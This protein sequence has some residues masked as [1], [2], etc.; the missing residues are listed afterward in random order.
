MQQ[1]IIMKKTIYEVEKTCPFLE[2]GRKLNLN[3][4]LRGSYLIVILWI[5][6]SLC[7]FGK[8]FR[9]FLNHKVDGPQMSQFSRNWHCYGWPKVGD[10]KYP[11]QDGAWYVFE[12]GIVITN[13][14]L[15]VLLLVGMIKR[16][17]MMMVPWIIFRIVIILVS[18]FCFPP[19][20]LLTLLF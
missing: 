1:F 20:S 4:Y 17:Y 3:N 7:I 15:V 8:E 10:R 16:K 14:F 6:A 18:S 11:C 2:K 13:T 9:D 12:F 5:I 19:L